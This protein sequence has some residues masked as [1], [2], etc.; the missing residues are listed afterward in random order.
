[1]KKPRHK[2]VKLNRREILYQYLIG[3][4]LYANV[5]GQSLSSIEHD[6]ERGNTYFSRDFKVGDI[7][8]TTGSLLFNNNPWCIGFCDVKLSKSEVVIKDIFSGVLCRYENESYNSVHNLPHYL[9]LIDKDYHLYKR[10]SNACRKVDPYDLIPCGS[11]VINDGIIVL[12][13]RKWSSD[14]SGR[15]TVKYG[16]LSRDMIKYLKEDNQNVKE[17]D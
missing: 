1:M 14:I 5:W 3:T 17:N 16:T 13:R 2:D 10:F 12:T 8:L 11:E 4:M 6:K 7:I 15:H 9:T